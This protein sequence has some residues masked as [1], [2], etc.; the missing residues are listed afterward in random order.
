MILQLPLS[1]DPAQTFICQLDKDKYQFTVKYN[2][3]SGVWAMDMVKLDGTILF[4]GIPILLGND[5]LEPY[6]YG[7]GRLFVIDLS[8][9]SRDATNETD[10]LGTRVIVAW[11][12]KDEVIA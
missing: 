11:F 10:D 1:S 4:I 9:Q 6:N 5:L 3:R 2:S 12:S 7:I 8:A